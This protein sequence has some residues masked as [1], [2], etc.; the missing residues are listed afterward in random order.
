[1][2]KALT[3][4]G[5]NVLAVDMLGYGSAPKPSS[6]W[7]LAEELEHL[8]RTIDQRGLDRIHLVPHSLG[9][10]FDFTCAESSANASR[11]S[12]SSIRSCSAS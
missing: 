3:A 8:V 6:G 11:A 2:T 10:F 7:T 12:R 4:A 1:V 5:A 9:V